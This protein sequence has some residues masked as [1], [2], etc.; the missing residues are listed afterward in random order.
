M[1]EGTH[2]WNLYTYNQL[3]YHNLV[4]YD[5]VNRNKVSVRQLSLFLFFLLPTHYMFRPLQAIF[6]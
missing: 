3:L 4:S 5:A 1:E 2:I 6:R